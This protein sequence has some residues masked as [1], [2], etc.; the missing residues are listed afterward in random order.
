L[1]RSALG[2]ESVGEG[3]EMTKGRVPERRSALSK[4]LAELEAPRLESAHAAP[5]AAEPGYLVSA[6]VEEMP[7]GIILVG[8]EGKVAYA[9]KACERLLGYEASELIG[10]SALDLPTYSESKDRDRARHILRK[11]I[12][13]GSSEAFDM[14]V[15]RKDGTEVP[16]SFTASVIGGAQGSPSMLIA[17]IR[18]VTERKRAEEAL[19]QSEEHY[20]ALVG[21]MTDAVFKFTGNK[22]T[23][24]NEAV[25]DVYGYKPAE[26]IGKDVGFLGPMDTD[27]VEFS[28]VIASSMEEGGRFCDVARVKRKD[29]SVVDVEYTVSEVKQAQ[30]DHPVEV[31]AVARDIS[32]RRLMEEALRE[33]EELSRGMLDTAAT[34]I[35]LLQDGCFMYVN[36]LFEEISGYTSSELVGTH[37]LD[38]V[39]PEDRDD[40]RAKAIDVLRGKSCEPYEF[41]FVRKDGR[42]IWVSDRLTSIWYKGKRSVLGTLTDIT[43][44]KKIEMEVLEYTRQIE[45]LF[46]IGA[47]VNRTLNVG[48]LLD[49]VLDK[50]LGVME[51]EAGGVFLVDRESAELILRAYKGAS[52]EFAT[53]VEGVRLGEGFTRRAALSKKP[54]IVEDIAADP[55]LGRM[56]ALEEGLRSLVAVPIVAKDELLGVIGV[57]S[58]E[59]RRFLDRDVRLMGAIANQIGMA[60]ENAQLY[61]QALTLAFTDGLT[62]LYNRRYLM[63]QIERE[64]NRVER[65]KGT[66]SLVMIDL[67]G[68]KGI[69]DRFGHHE[70]DVI[71]KR[72]GAVIKENTRVSDVAARWG[73]D[74]FMLLTHDANSKG[75]RRIAERIRSQV[76]RTC[77]V[78]QGEEVCVSISVGIASYPGHA[79]D[80]TQLLQRVD[81]AM[82]YAKE[83]G[84]NRLRIFSRRE[85]R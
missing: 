1:G 16:V 48:E 54:L 47:T 22:I 82:Y 3:L 12:G 21:G 80:V 45:T 15:I 46:N 75:A 28:K 33:S 7:D 40:V 81:E 5:S 68:L 85:G 78:I 41:R 69:N 73:G 36:R 27:L 29:G 35:Y 44:R 26:L 57:A 38:C 31:V 4:K 34:G 23:W 63:E 32:E 74:E 58:R 37:S 43:E 84:G 17:V 25:E 52:A 62:G 49:V 51:A 59:L 19:R 18:D 72:L 60:I 11:V 24:C 55:R 56:G 66:L 30:G 14:T 65:N 6:A 70:G 61:E 42:T 8:M 79:A 53:K 50:V 64:F 77:P 9:N 2:S 83:S 13:G 67:D 76:G 39:C 10:K 71:L 20:A